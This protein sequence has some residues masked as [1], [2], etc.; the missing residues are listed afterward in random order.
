MSAER[1][2][3]LHGN[4]SLTAYGIHTKL[5]WAFRSDPG[6][7]RES[8]EDY[9]DSFVPAAPEDAW[10]RGPLFVIADGMG[11]HAA[12]EVAS[13]LA[14]DATLQSWCAGQAGAPAQDLRRA[15]RAANVSVYDESVQPGHHGM[16]T[17]VIAFTLAGHEAIFGHV[18]DSRAYLVRTG[19]CVQLTSDHSRVGEMVRMRLLT[20]EEAAN[21]PGRSQLTRSLGGEPGVQ[22]EMTKQTVQR[23]DTVLLCTDGVWDVVSRPEMAAA[24]AAHVDEPGAAPMAQVDAL[25]EL[26][27]KRGAPDNVTALVVTITSPLPVMAATGRRFFRRGR[28]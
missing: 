9:A 17:T 22:V 28:S 24:V 27:L 12:G 11:G 4:G 18:G 25:L 13:R 26:A 2:D 16:G 15:V 3:E 6:V 19:E 5:S 23:G 7:V 8:N 21:H 1:D 10:E 20:P 14:V